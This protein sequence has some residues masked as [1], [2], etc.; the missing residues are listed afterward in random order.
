[1]ELFR[2]LGTIAIDNDQANRALDETGQRAQETSQETESAFAKIGTAAGK[3]AKGIGVASIAL[4]G[5]WLAAIEGSREYRTEM[6]KLDT[7]FVTN[8][9]SSEVAKQTYSDLN[10]VLGDS[11]QATEAA[12]HLAK[13]T[14]NEK[15]LQTWTDICTGV[16]ATFGESLPIEGLTEAANET[17]KTGILTGGLTDALNWAG[18]SEEQF[19]EKL[20]A[21]SNEQER[22]KL[23]ME[24]LNGTYSKAS[25][26]YK[27]TNKDVMDAQRAQEKLTDAFAKLGA[28]GEP[29]LTAIKEKVAE[30]VT[31]AVP[32]L[33]SFI[34]KVKDIS[35][36]VKDNQDT[37]DAWVAVIIGAGTA[38]G[39]F[40]LILNWGKIMT[41]AANAIKVVRTAI[42]A[43]N[44]AMLANPIG[45]IVA[46]IAGLV[47]AFIYLWNNVEGFRKFW[48]KAWNLIKDGA[49]KAW[50]AIKKALGNIGSWFSDKFKQVQKAGK[51]AWNGI[52][53]AWNSAGKWFSNMASKI[54]NAFSNIPSWFKSKFK[55]AWSSIKAVFSGWGSFFGGLWTKI[56][57]KFGSIG[58]SIGKTMGNA[59]KSGLNKVLSTVEKTINK[60]IG[61]IN[62]A[63]RLAN[64]L[65]GINVGTVSK[66][67]LPRLAKGGVLEKGQVG[68]LEGSGAEAV[69]PLERNHAWLSK[70]AA[71]LNELQGNT[72][73]NGT[74]LQI[75]SV[76]DRIVE[77]L[78]E[79]SKM[80]I[81][82][83]SGVMVGELI[84]AIDTKM[85]D[86]WNH[87]LRGSTR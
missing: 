86:R 81:F 30:M 72:F 19:Q 49:V 77:L 48:I 47:A 73:Q 31:A 43:M 67:S 7:A 76:L 58:T 26:Q 21:C 55:S 25:E 62:S 60:G 75:K 42:L 63:I 65:P 66:I 39:T 84:P 23:I 3:I 50:N 24:T 5:A 69:V 87:A 79:L 74:S 28:V 70:V 37:I 4:G 82:L 29:I 6:G 56:K 46:L 52:K 27:K 13:L 32:Y 78:Q 54:K 8:G 18:I 35:T 80:K 44:A 36:W 51:D 14:D 12:Q 10:A 11:G 59:V 68:L 1:M 34:Q 53:N 85:S 71:D 17:A 9:H 41:A 38:I 16:Y 15:E 33:E 2:L 40:L 64:K 45:L 57:S 20:D 83:D 22:Q 61:L